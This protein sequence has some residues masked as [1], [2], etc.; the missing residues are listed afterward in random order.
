[1]QELMTLL[2]QRRNCRNW[3]KEMKGKKLGDF[4]EKLVEL[5]PSSI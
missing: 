1:M 2:K 3:K 5:T 4:R